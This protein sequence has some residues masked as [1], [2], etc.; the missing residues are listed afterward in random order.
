ME[1]GKD[2]LSN[3]GM[4][5]PNEAFKFEDIVEDPLGAPIYADCP[6][7]GELCACT[8]KCRV[9]IGHTTEPERLSA[10]RERIKKLNEFQKGGMQNL[11][12][13]RKWDGGSEIEF[14]TNRKP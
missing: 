1:Q 13:E 8:G 7:K 4:F 2:Y 9:V 10:Y 14:I 11:Y 6:A 5:I 3:F 12:G